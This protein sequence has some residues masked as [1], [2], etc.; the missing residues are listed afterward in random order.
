MGYIK[1][2]G[3]IIGYSATPSDPSPN[4]ANVGSGQ[5]TQSR[6]QGRLAE[7]ATQDQDLNYF[8]QM[9]PGKFP[10][11]HIPGSNRDGKIVTNPGLRNT[12]WL[13]TDDI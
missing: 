10:R 12:G 11:G 2:N 3:K 13:P 4:P 9:E 7:E 1:K 6:S 5:P 8:E